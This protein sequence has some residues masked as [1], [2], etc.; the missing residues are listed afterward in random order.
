MFFLLFFGIMPGQEAI[1][2]QY[3]IMQAITG[4]WLFLGIAM[5]VWAMYNI[6]CISFFLREI[7]QP[8][9]S[10]VYNLQAIDN[11]RQY[12]QLFQV[13]AGMYFPGIIYGVFTAIVGIKEHCYFQSLIVLV[14]QL[15]MCVVG[16]M[17]YFN[18]INTTWNRPAIRLPNL[19]PFRKKSFSF[20]L[21]HYSLYYKKGAFIAIKL[22]SLLMLQFMVAAN[23]EKVSKEAIC[24]LIMFLISAHS[25]LPRFYVSF[26]ENELAFLRNL[27]V[28][29]LRRF[30]VFTVT[31]AVI[32]LPE[33]LFLIW[34]ERQV[35]PPQLIISLYAI[36]ISQLCLYTALQYLPNMQTER[37]TFIVFGLFFASL[38][39]LATLNLWI[40][41]FAEALISK[42]VFLVF[43][44]GYELAGEKKE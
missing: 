32:F 27:P 6:K 34:N 36:S 7:H 24:V 42:L 31:Y 18:S 43:Y 22:F 9:N 5:L 37:Y 17:V 20:Y 28:T 4:S 14:F 21:L 11:K 41:F 29:T 12:F 26:M 25:L 38:L 13:Q 33:L 2:F 3:A 35:M 15:F 1:K 30:L 39:L 19:D 23:S 8:E 40:L 10:F 16:A 44:N